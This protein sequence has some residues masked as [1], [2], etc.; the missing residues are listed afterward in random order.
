M[1]SLEEHEKI[2]SKLHV[3][4]ILWWFSNDFMYGSVSSK[5]NVNLSRCLLC[6]EEELRF[7][8]KHRFNEMLV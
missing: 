8:M 5:K 2:P 1:V 6:I 3:L 4:M 7:R